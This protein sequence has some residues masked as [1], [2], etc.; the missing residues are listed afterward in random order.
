MHTYNTYYW[1]CDLQGDFMVIYVMWIWDM[2]LF[3]LGI[4][5]NSYVIALSLIISFEEFNNKQ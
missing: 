5:R 3:I 1:I 2:T 4:C